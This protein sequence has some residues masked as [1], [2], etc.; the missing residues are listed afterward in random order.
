MTIYPAI[1]IKDGVAVRLMQGLADRKT[2]YFKDPLEPARNFQE[3]GAEWV[4]VVDLDGAFTGTA[5]NLHHIERIA[6]LGLKVQMGGG[7]RSGGDI[8]RLLNAGVARFVVGTRACESMEFVQ[9]MAERWPD[10]A[11]VGIDARDGMAAI[12]GWVDVTA[13]T[14]IDLAQAV[15]QAGIKIIIYTDISTDGMMTGPNFE[16]Q[17]Q[18]WQAVASTP[19]RVIASGGVHDPHDIHHYREL[20]ARFPN[21]EGPIVGKALYEGTVPLEGLFR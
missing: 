21:F 6:A 19:A 13:I 2:E 3:A 10:Q 5:R 8:E 7:V 1:D 14:A 18:V 15:A 12:H 11:A 9:E 20:A 17:K 4:H 16:G